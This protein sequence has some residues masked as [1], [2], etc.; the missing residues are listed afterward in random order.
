MFGYNRNPISGEAQQSLW[1]HLKLKR[2]GYWSIA[3]FD[4][5]WM[6]TLRSLGALAHLRSH[7]TIR[8]AITNRTVLRT[9]VPKILSYGYLPLLLSPT[10]LFPYLRFLPHHLPPLPFFL[11]F[12]MHFQ[13]STPFRQENRLTES[14]FCVSV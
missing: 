1:V 8:Q 6:A 14:P 11:H 7:K 3:R 9:K 12:V 4:R 5:T 10:P 13:T 2:I